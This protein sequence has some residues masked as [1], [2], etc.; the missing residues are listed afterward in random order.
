MEFAEPN[1][2]IS[3]VVYSFDGNNLKIL[4]KKESNRRNADDQYTLPEL[5]LN[6]DESMEEGVNRLLSVIFNMQPL[7]IDQVFTHHTKN[8]IKRAGFFNFKSAVSGPSSSY[9]TIVYSALSNKLSEIRE[10]DSNNYLWFN[11]DALPFLGDK[12]ELFMQRTHEKL[13]SEVLNSPNLF[14]LLPEKFTIPQLQNL[15]EKILDTKFDKRNFRKKVNSMKFLI[16]LE[17]KDR[18]KFGKPARLFF[19]S[20]DVHDKLY[21]NKF[22]ISIYNGA[23]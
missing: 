10:I 3:C 11:T 1:V 12:H 6:Q 5:I 7:F 4:L 14:K 16:P 2:I 9:L 13:K 22:R 18:S 17:E 20:S 19:F 23:Y 8:S 21:R 15:C